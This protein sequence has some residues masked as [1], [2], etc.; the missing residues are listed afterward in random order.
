MIYFT[1]AVDAAMTTRLQKAKKTLEITSGST[2]STGNQ[3]SYSFSFNKYINM[4]KNGC[5]GLTVMIF[6][7][8]PMEPGSTPGRGPQTNFDSDLLHKHH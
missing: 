6:G 4:E 7:C 8:G 1:A 2:L 5:G 3:I